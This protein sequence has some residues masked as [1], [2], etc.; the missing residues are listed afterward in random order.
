MAFGRLG[1]A[2]GE[3]PVDIELPSRDRLSLCRVSSAEHDAEDG[4]F[5][6]PQN[7]FPPSWLRDWRDT[8]FLMPLPPR[9]TRAPLGIFYPS[10]SPS[11]PFPI[12]RTPPASHDPLLFAVVR[13]RSR[14]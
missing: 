4:L 13:V 10:S 3:A 8:L 12:C 6:A 9:T 14:P 5:V 7:P 11:V 2:L 1:K